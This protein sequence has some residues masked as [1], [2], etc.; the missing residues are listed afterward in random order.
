MP[1]GQE[2]L[3]FNMR[4]AARFSSQLAEDPV[5][6]YYILERARRSLNN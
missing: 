5:R 4:E 3:L 2:Q 1:M 6:F